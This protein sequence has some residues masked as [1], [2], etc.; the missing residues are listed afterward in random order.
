M[1]FGKLGNVVDAEIIYN[2]KGSKGFGFVTMS[3][4]RDADNAL[5][6]LNQSIV[7][8]RVIEVNVAI[9]KTKKTPAP[10]D[11]VPAGVSYAYRKAAAPPSPS[12]TSPRT[13]ASSQILLEAEA[14][15]AEAKME[16]SKI[17]RQ[18]KME[19]FLCQSTACV[20]LSSLHL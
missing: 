5:I 17:R 6:R 2:D 4:G 1:L 14:K 15:V 20:D 12:S 19:R 11:S 13:L 16:V 18:M 8:G 10:G 7:E 3:R 9:P